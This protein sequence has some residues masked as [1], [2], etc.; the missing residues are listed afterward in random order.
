[1]SIVMTF[2]GVDGRQVPEIQPIR[3]GGTRICPY[4]KSHIIRA[5]KWDLHLM[6][7][8]ENNPNSG[9][10]TCKYVYGHHIP[11]EDIEEH[12]KECFEE[13]FNN[14]NKTPLND[15][16]F[17]IPDPLKSHTNGSVSSS[18]PE[19]EEEVQVNDQAA[20]EDPDGKPR[21][22]ENSGETNRGMPETDGHDIYKCDL[23][24]V[25]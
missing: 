18:D 8:R 17:V 22:F 11:K 1:M 21:T 13:H 24:M 23:C 6:K 7:C 16:T 15:K 10:A 20:N 5:P 12:E 2:Y 4:N 25:D 3:N 19:W 9:I 14:G